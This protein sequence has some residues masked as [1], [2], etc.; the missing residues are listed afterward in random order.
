M[1]TTRV[2]GSTTTAKKAEAIN[3]N[4]LTKAASKGLSEVHRIR[5]LQIQKD[6]I[7]AKYGSEFLRKYVF[8]LLQES[9]KAG[10]NEEIQSIENTYRY[11]DTISGEL[12]K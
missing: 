9:E 4:L 10:F 12:E 6:K 8:G 7:R 3:E 11:L 1:S 2:A 5:T